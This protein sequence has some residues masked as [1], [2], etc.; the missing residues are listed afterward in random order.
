MKNKNYKSASF[1]KHPLFW[2]G[3]LL[4]C[5]L[6]VGV[7]LKLTHKADSNANKLAAP[8]KNQAA[9]PAG[10]TNYN[11]PTNQDIQEAEQ[12]KKELAN[13][14][15]ETQNTGI[16]NVKPTITYAAQSGSQI[17]V[18]AFVPGVIEEGGTC[19]L[20]L[21]KGTK[22]IT[23]QTLGVRN[24]TTT[25]CPAFN[26]ERSEFSESGTWVATVSYASKIASGSS[27]ISNLEIQ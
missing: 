17:E 24:A 21:I 10:T 19:T 7:T 11:P 3:L 18:N 1:F 12:H 8:T 13:S 16:K 15:Q 23:K 14:T 5:L 22:T 9:Q 25:S 27:D 20:K 26:F 2:V 4:L 6:L